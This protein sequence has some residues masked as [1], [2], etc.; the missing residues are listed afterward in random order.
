MLLA[1]KDDDNIQGLNLLYNN[2]VSAAEIVDYCQSIGYNRPAKK[3]L[4]VLNE[5]KFSKL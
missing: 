4:H 2:T 1:I 5:A 3:Y